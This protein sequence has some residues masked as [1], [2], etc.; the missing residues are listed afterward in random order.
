M[1]GSRHLPIVTLNPPRAQM[2]A[3]LAGLRD[4]YGTDCG[5]ADDRVRDGGPGGVPEGRVI[6]KITT[7]LTT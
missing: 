1:V 3:Q 4:D 5:S 7:G 6:R 2:R